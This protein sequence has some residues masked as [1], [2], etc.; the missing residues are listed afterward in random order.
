M[1]KISAIPNK[2]VNHLSGVFQT[3]EF[4]LGA[5]T[6]F[7]KA[8][9]HKNEGLVLFVTPENAIFLKEHFAF[10]LPD[11]SNVVQRKQIHF[12][13][14]NQAIDF[15]YLGNRVSEEKFNLLI[16]SSLSTMK[17]RFHSVRVYSELEMVM[18]YKSKDAAQKV[19]DC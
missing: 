16:G 11:Y 19:E 12:L 15:F 14:V 3:R 1:T 13:D 17:N 5:I 4:L 10:A 2:N 9:L 8:G 18:S 6:E 7:L